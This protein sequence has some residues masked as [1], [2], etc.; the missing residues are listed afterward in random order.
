MFIRCFVYANKKDDAQEIIERSLRMMQ[1]NIVEKKNICIE[2]YWKIDGMYQ[3][4]LE[5]ELDKRR[6]YETVA[7]FL[8]SISKCWIQYCSPINNEI[9][10]SQSEEN[11]H[12]VNE[13]I[14]FIDIVFEDSEL[15]FLEDSK[16]F[17]T[18][19]ES[20]DK[21][22]DITGKE[23]FGIDCSKG[24]IFISFFGNGRLE[25]K[26]WAGILNA[27]KLGLNRDKQIK[28]MA[29]LL[30]EEVTYISWYYHLCGQSSAAYAKDENS[31]EEV[32]VWEW[33]DKKKRAK[34]IGYPIN[35][36]IGSNIG[37]GEAIIYCKGKVHLIYDEHMIVNVRQNSSP[38]KKDAIDFEDCS[39][40]YFVY[41]QEK[42]RREILSILH[43]FC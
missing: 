37:E 36:R 23:R 17:V 19:I 1:D 26:L 6:N 35:G 25:L 30:F 32:F 42:T 14:N 12:M 33:G 5:L 41:Q 40:D 43:E 34:S 24:Y 22:I 2:A 20:R 9:L 10:A 3:I 7:L 15:C 28:G 11:C 29:T 18:L 31:K 16:K 4:E 21:I 27:K 39:K 8:N 38:F 13:K